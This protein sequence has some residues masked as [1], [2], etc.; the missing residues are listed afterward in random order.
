MKDY[1]NNT[2]F[3]YD[4]LQ[5]NKELSIVYVSGNTFNNNINYYYTNNNVDFEKENL[6]KNILD[7]KIEIKSLIHE[8]Y[9]FFDIKKIDFLKK[10]TK[11]VCTK[12]IDLHYLDMLNANTELLIECID[13]EEDKKSNPISWSDAFGLHNGNTIIYNNTT[14]S[15]GTFS[16]SDLPIV[17]YTLTN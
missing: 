2:T 5:S 3:S 10:N 11:I 12:Q 17:N 13:A 9:E 16:T 14:Y 7:K 8:G 15:T 6:I 1:F 4:F